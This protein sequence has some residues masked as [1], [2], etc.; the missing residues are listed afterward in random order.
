MKRMF[1]NFT[2]ALA[3]IGCSAL[4]SSSLLAQGHGPALSGEV[5]DQ[6]GLPI[7]AVTVSV[8]GP[9]GAALVAQTNEEGKYVFR[10]LPAGTYSVR[11][12]LKGFSTFE[13][14]G[15]VIA[16]GKP[17][18]VDAQMEVTMEKQKVNVQSEAQQLSVS[19]ENNASALV[20]KGEAL[21][22]LSEDPDELQQELQEL[23]GPAAG[24]N[25]GQIYID[26]F[27]GGQ[28]PPKEA[29]LEVRVNQNPFTA[30][31][32]RLGYGR[33]DIITKP[34][35]QKFH[36]G[37][38]GFGNNSAFNARNPFVTQEPN[39][40]SEFL[41]ANIGGPL[42]KKVSFYFNVFRRKGIGN[43]IVSAE[44]LDPNFNAAPLSEAV[45]NQR[46]FTHYNPRFDFQLASK[47]VL[48]FRGEF[49]TNNSSN[50]GIGQFNLP[51]LANNSNG[52]GNEIH[53]SD[54][55]IVS[56][57]TVM[58]T[59]FG[60]EHDHSTNLPFSV[61]PAIRVI[62]A[63]NG[64]GSSGG[65]SVDTTNHW[66]IRNTTSTAFNKHSLTYGGEL[67]RYWESVN[68]LGGFNGSFTFPSLTAY[69]ITEQGIALGQTAAEIRAAGGGASQFV[70]TAGNPVASANV[71]D[72]S[73]YAEDSWRVRPNIS[74]SY[75]VRFETQNRISDHADFMPRLGF[76]WGLGHGAK[77]LTVVRAGFGIF[78]DRFG[79]SQIL[80]AEQLN[81]INEQ[82]YVV[83]QP[84]FFPNIPPTSTLVNFATF[85]TM[86]QIDPHLHAPYTMEGAA[87]IERQIGNKMTAA[88]T[89]INSHGVHQLL[90]NNINA[91]LPGTYNPAD[92][93]SG[94]RPFGNVGNIYQFESVGIFNEN[95]VIAN[96]SVRATSNLNL[97]ANYTLSYANSDT[98]GVGSFPMNPYDIRADYGPAAFAIRNRV[99]VG[100][101]MGLPFGLQF[102]P[103]LVV[104]SG[105]PYNITLGQD[106][107]GTSIFNFRPAF[108]AAGATGP[109]IIA[110][111]F[112]TFDIAPAPGQ[113]VIP[114]NYLVGPGQF[115]M[116][117]RISK[118]FGFGKVAEGG[119]GFS[120][121]HHYGHG[122]G[123]RGGLTGNSG[124]GGFFGHGSSENHRY[125]VEIGA[126][127]HNV[128]NKVNLGTPV[129]NLG[130]PLFG[131][132]NS[133]A[134][135]FFGGGDANRSINL[136]LRF[137]F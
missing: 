33:I 67:R 88:V 136:F 65:P 131:Q 40:H 100:G 103:F 66:E 37:V 13:K 31:Y 51:S 125:T 21:K 23:A 35:Y 56:D 128:F 83:N 105:R 94:V 28:L 78:Y 109:N 22:S 124:G 15:I 122:G 80:R 107:L 7:P 70:I 34:G 82:Q 3:V 108:A 135:G 130:S 6:S 72:L 137:N 95:Q 96:F 133:L 74:L 2:L 8:T 76:A 49:S 134:S 59:L 57:R 38:F 71:T 127:T 119:G 53:I 114:I 101:S 18:V 92:P 48:T 102:S 43:S 75:G 113:A 81:G 90:T 91:P 121:D 10:N 112:G 120:G 115:S 98:G 39:Y 54:T 68:A 5:K 110:T 73:L 99:F 129:G 25:G 41:N 85:P 42:G 52:D 61:D 26:G 58:Q 45:R 69:Q 1:K 4:F 17:Q 64:G 50:N 84:D 117:A 11:I 111:Q 106:L 47:N 89:Y 9:G 16:P 46:T 97:S 60:Y 77:P 32:E 55:Q 79:Q 24:P 93:T 20:I 126:M 30:Q 87:S 123:L 132:S 62:G 29:I 118:T 36:G 116:N 104:E 27:T 86:Y 12:E 44:V 19:A 14:T 63:F